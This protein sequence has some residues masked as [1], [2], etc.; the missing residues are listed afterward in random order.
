MESS[1]Q[2]ILY[3]AYAYTIVLLFFYKWRGFS[4][5]LF[6]WSIFTISSWCSYWFYNNPLTPVLLDKLYNPQTPF[7]FVYLFVVLF[8]FIQPLTKIKQFDINNLNLDFYIRKLKPLLVLIIIYQIIYVIVDSPIVINILSSGEGMLAD[9]RSNVYESTNSNMLQIKFIRNF[10]GIYNGIKPLVY[11]IALISFVFHNN[12]KDKLLV[13]ILFTT[14]LLDVIR[15][16]VVVVSRGILANYLFLSFGIFL[17]FWKNLS[18]KARRTLL[19]YVTPILVIAIIFLQAISV[20]RFGDLATLYLSRYLGESMT[21]FNGILF[22]D[23][24]GIAYGHAYFNRI[25]ELFS[26]KDYVTAIQKWDFIE[27]VSGVEGGIFYTFVGSLIIDFGKEMTFLFAL[28]YNICLNRTFMK[29]EVNALGKVILVVFL[30]YWISTGLFTT[31][32]QDYGNYLLIAVP[33]L[34]YYFKLKYKKN[35]NRNIN[36]L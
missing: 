26:I 19:F 10:Y 2:Y 5:G 15:E 1:L 13:R 18:R 21:N 30:I 8:L 28:V 20:S 29:L 33:L 24:K 12:A 7:G 36:I 11:A 9:Y 22:S 17:L 6:L 32:I 3:N 31:Q 14:T 27:K 16:I 25:F 34:Y 4:V 23:L 35:E